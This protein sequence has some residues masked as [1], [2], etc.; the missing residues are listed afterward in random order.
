M[1]KWTE[2]YKVIG[3][4]PGKIHTRKFGIIDFSKD[5]IPVEKCDKLYESGFPYL[6]KIKTTA[7]TVIKK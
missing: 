5:S 6:E 4:K 7:T 3:V 2:K 1:T